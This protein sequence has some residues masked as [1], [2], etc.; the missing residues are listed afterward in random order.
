[1]TRSQK[2]WRLNSEEADREYT[3]EQIEN[4]EK[5]KPLK[6]RLKLLTN[7]EGATLQLVKIVVASFI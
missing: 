5:G 3:S 2:W 1:M 4:L 7:M 6:M